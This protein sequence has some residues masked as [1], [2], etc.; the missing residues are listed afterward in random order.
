M[1]L[2]AFGF[3]LAAIGAYFIFFRPALLPE[4]LRYLEVSL[5]RINDV[6]PN[7]PARLGQ[8]FRVLGGH[9]LAAG[10]LTIFVARTAYREHSPGTGIFA[11]PAGAA[12]IGM[13]IIVNF[14]IDSDF[15]WLLLA[16]AA[17]WLGS[18]SMYLPEGRRR[19]RSKDTG[20]GAIA[21]SGMTA[22]D[23]PDP[24]RLHAQYRDI[25]A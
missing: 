22:A 23:Q 15:K 21:H 9:M 12:S 4:D 6:A 24:T 10:I 14:A 20:T 2:M 5:A 8:V 11:L 16:V 1:L 3:I 19:V 25:V 18:I 13:M 17:V 7:L